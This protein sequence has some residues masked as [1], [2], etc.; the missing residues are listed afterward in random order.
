MKKPISVILCAVLL[1]SLLAGCGKEEPQESVEVT[2][3]APTTAA[4]TTEP[5]T[6]MPATSDEATSAVKYDFVAIKQDAD[7]INSEFNSSVKAGQFDGSIYMKLGN[8]FEYIST[9]GYADVDNHIDNSV[10]TCYYAGNITA[11]FTAVAVLKLAE[12][13]KLSLD[14]PINEYFPKLERRD[15][16]TVRDLLENTSG[17]KDYVDHIGTSNK[18]YFLRSDFDDEITEENDS[19]KNKSIIFDWIM[20]STSEFEPGTRRGYSNSNWFLLGKIIESVTESP[21]EVYITQNF[22][23]PLG[24]RSSSF[25]SK[26]RLAVAYGGRESG[27]KL[28]YFGVG[29][30]AFGLI[31]TVSDMLKW[32]E[33]IASGSILSE[34]S[35]KL[36]FSANKEETEEPCANYGIEYDGNTAS[37]F[38]ECGAYRSALCYTLDKSEVFIS[39]SNSYN[40]NPES[41]YEEFKGSLRRYVR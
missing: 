6:T 12:E 29:Y 35:E 21:Y 24:M 14:E 4:P 40:S 11:Q 3:V 37:V 38:S 15:K 13:G 17:I 22:F 7:K 10:N 1:I 18:I 25:D 16:I 34:E 27:K 31:T 41:L 9:T 30:S 39:F 26:N 20:S 8:D 23:N 33:A 2:T 19:K 28:N 5:A 32:S 36:M